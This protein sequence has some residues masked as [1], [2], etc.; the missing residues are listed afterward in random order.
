V[1]VYGVVLL[2]KMVM[3]SVDPE[4]ELS[5]LKYQYKGA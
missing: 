1:V 5:G 4:S 3:A 2:A